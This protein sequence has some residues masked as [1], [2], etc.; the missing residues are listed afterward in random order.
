MN[1]LVLVFCLFVVAPAYASQPEDACRV[2]ANKTLA[3]IAG[4]GLEVGLMSLWDP[5]ETCKW[6]DKH[7]TA[8]PKV[9]WVDRHARLALMN[10][11]TRK[12]AGT[13]SDVTLITS[14]AGSM[15]AA[16]NIHDGCRRRFAALRRVIVAVSIT[17]AATGTLKR[18]AG[19]SRPGHRF[20]PERGIIV[21]E[22]RFVSF[23]SGHSSGAFAAV[24]ALLAACEDCKQKRWLKP[25]GLSLAGATA[26][27]RVGAEKHYLT[28]ITAGALLG[29]G[30][31][32]AVAKVGGRF[33]SS[34]TVTFAPVRQN[35]AVGLKGTVVW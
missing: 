10:H 15:L 17:D 33:D 26:V 19:R 30:V 8:S 32:S 5:P 21:G 31:S 4:A 28:D 6:C 20:F 11:D 12:V 23:P 25:L 22:D 34:T 35:G 18:L 3:V 27:L 29:W 24:T 7:S 1:R 14:V 2:E 9:N 16:F 13:V